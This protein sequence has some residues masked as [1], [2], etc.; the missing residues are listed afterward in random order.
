MTEYAH[1]TFGE[2]R[3]PELTDETLVC[4]ESQVPGGDKLRYLRFDDGWAL[5][6]VV[7]P[8]DDTLMRRRDEHDEAMGPAALETWYQI[9]L[10]Q[11]GQRDV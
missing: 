4:A 8:E 7:S 2:A 11:T 1:L 10:R 6:G 3:L 9:Y 5:A